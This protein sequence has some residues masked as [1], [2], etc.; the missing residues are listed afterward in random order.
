MI[1]IK[2]YRI[3]CGSYTPN[4][5][6]MW[7]HYAD[8]HKG[9][10]LEFKL[11]NEDGTNVFIFSKEDKMQVSEVTYT[12]EPI[13]IL[14]MPLDEV[15]KLDVGLLS[16]KS[17]RWAYEKEIRIIGNE[18]EFLK[19]N[20]NSLVNIIFGCKSTKK[21]R[22]TIAF[23]LR[24]SGYKCPH[25]LAKMKPDIYEM[26]IEQMIFNDVAGG[27]FYWEDLNYEK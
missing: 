5:P 20:R 19:F 6:V 2:N 1:N 10:C 13:D 23:H 9:V 12:D 17:E 25:L 26:K 11:F 22:W 18:K 14:N 16:T 3:T 27:G 15:R 7:G 4:C 21:D 24:N 8:N